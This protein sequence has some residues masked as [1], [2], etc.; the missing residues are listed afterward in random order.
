MVGM[1]VID[2][3]E[4]ALVCYSHIML[5]KSS[6]ASYL[7]LA[8]HINANVIVESDSVNAVCCASSLAAALW[9]FQFHMN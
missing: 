6:L 5:V 3:E 1:E 9:R 7:S 2:V 4:Q 8:P